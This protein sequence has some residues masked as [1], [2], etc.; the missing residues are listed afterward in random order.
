[1]ASS[2]SYHDAIMRKEYVSNNEFVADDDHPEAV[3]TSIEDSDNED[4]LH[5]LKSL[6]KH[7]YKPYWFAGILAFSLFLERFCFVVTVYKTREHGY[8]LILCVAFLNSMFALF[9]SLIKKKKHKRKLYEY[10]Q[11]KKTPNVGVCIFA[12]I[13]ILDMFY[14]F[15]LFWPANV[16]PIANLITLLQLFIP[17]NMVIRKF[18]LYHSQY[19]IHWM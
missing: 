12:L 13:S 14:V 19:Y 16:I 8:V 7:E 9:Q 18:F 4:T 2:D 3:P 5:W 15:F 10:F 17:L 6:F 11:L 1:M